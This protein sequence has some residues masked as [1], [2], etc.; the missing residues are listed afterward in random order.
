MAQNR[1][2]ID[3]GAFQ[4]MFLNDCF[5][6]LEKISVF[7]QGACYR[8]RNFFFVGEKKILPCK[9]KHIE[10]LLLN[11][12]S[13]GIN[14]LA[15]HFALDSEEFKFVVNSFYQI[16]ANHLSVFFPFFACLVGGSHSSTP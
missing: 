13:Q 9:L 1:A 6:S 7:P 10:C 2:T 8:L 4:I 11:P 12:S 15:L 14:N 16:F 3:C 5:F